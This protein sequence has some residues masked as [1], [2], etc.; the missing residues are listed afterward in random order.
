[1]SRKDRYEDERLDHVIRF[2]HLA[3]DFRWFGIGSLLSLLSDASTS[4]SEQPI[5][6]LAALEAESSGLWRLSFVEN[7]WDATSTRAPETPFFIIDHDDFVDDNG[8][9]RD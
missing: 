7:G 9:R 5:S 8:A 2:N 3:R 4:K 1:M 6:R